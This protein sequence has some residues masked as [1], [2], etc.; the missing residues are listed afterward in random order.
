MTQVAM[1]FISVFRTLSSD[2]EIAGNK[3]MQDTLMGLFFDN[4]DAEDILLLSNSN[5]H[6]PYCEGWNGLTC[7]HNNVIHVEYDGS[8]Y[9]TF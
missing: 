3:T 7:I 9:G 1:L 6:R 4:I 8:A 2:E 5:R